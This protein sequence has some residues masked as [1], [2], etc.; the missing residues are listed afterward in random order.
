MQVGEGGFEAATR[1]KVTLHWSQK[2]SSRGRNDYGP[3]GSI[4]FSTPESVQPLLCKSDFRL[5]EFRE[6]MMLIGFI[7]LDSM[8]S[9]SDIF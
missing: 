7:L 5:E 8:H 6:F 9:G 2:S 1:S 4:I 3:V